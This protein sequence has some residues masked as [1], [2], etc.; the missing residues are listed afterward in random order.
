MP[1]RSHASTLDSKDETT[2]DAVGD[3][4]KSTEMNSD[5]ETP[6]SNEQAVS[7]ATP[8]AAV[9]KEQDKD[10]EAPA[11][12]LEGA[13][14]TTE[15]SK[16]DFPEISDVKEANTVVEST[17][18]GVISQANNTDNPAATSEVSG[19]DAES[20]QAGGALD[21]VALTAM[22]EAAAMVMEAAKHQKKR[23]APETSHVDTRALAPK[24]TTPSR[25]SWQE[26]LEQLKEYKEEHGNLLIPIR[27]KLN[28]SLGKFVHNTREQYKLYHKKTPPGYKKKCSLTA[29][30]IE[31]LE[32][33][34]F[35]WTTER[36]KKQDESW[37]KRL[38]QLKAFKAKHGHTMVP[39]G[40][41]DDVPF[42]EWVHR[43]RTTY[44]SMLKD[45]KPSEA[46]QKRM[47]QLKDIGFNFTVHADKWLYHLEE[48]KFYKAQHGVSGSIRW[49]VVFAAGIFL[50]LT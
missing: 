25:T 20:E 47:Q 29:G 22:Q 50:S 41:F 35:A 28:P 11:P 9:L 32:A 14:G 27:Y 23:K 7:A 2:N 17:H 21:S 16:T 45:E 31:Q 44:A 37:S 36:T 1:T 5:D 10:T 42:A 15:D 48:L 4:C 46:V 13:M 30:R 39:H 43:Q 19:I 18:F 40:Y 24:R 33:L 26:R 34:G 12:S 49:A 6:A 3:A 38:E 8:A